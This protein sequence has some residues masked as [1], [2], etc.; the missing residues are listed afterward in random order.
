MVIR[1]KSERE[2]NERS[3]GQ[4]MLAALDQDGSWGC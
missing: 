3:A 1:C 2:V 4:Q